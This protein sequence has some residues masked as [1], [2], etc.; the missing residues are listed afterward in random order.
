MMLPILYCQ[1]L[2]VYFSF[3]ILFQ[4]SR[5]RWP[6]WPE[7]LL[8]PK[9]LSFSI[10]YNAP[11]HNSALRANPTA[12]GAGQQRR[13][14]SEVSSPARHTMQIGELLKAKQWRYCSAIM[15]P[16][17]A[18]ASKLAILLRTSWQKEGLVGSFWAVVPALQQ[19]VYSV[20][21]ATSESF[22]HFADKSIFFLLL[23][24]FKFSKL[25]KLFI[26]KLLIH[27]K[28]QTNLNVWPSSFPFKH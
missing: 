19:S 25:L 10:W 7:L 16:I 26:L 12:V 5:A 13:M 1:K 27:N 21:I 3:F 22:L 15:C 20:I 14:C 6:R 2:V 23:K 17:Q 11:S 18:L 8:V 28:Y 9:I 4:A 24:Y